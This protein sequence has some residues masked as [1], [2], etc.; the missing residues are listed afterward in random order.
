MNEELVLHILNTACYGLNL[1][2][3]LV[4]QPPYLYIFFDRSPEADL[5]YPTLTET[6]R[7]AAVSAGLPPEYEYLALYSRILGE[8]NPDWETAIYLYQSSI[9]PEASVQEPEAQQEQQDQ[10]QENQDLDIDSEPPI[11]SG[12]SETA[13]T[14]EAFLAESSLAESPSEPEAFA[15]FE[16]LFGVQGDGAANLPSDQ[17]LPDLDDEFTHDPT[18]VFEENFDD[19]AD[20]T[21]LD[22]PADS[23]DLLPLEQPAPQAIDPDQPLDS[24]PLDLQPEEPLLNDRDEPIDEV[25][26]DL[27]LDFSGGLPLPPPPPPPRPLQTAPDRAAAT[28]AKAEMADVATDKAA[29]DKVVTDKAA[30]DET[31]TDKAARAKADEDM[32]QY[33]FRAK[34]KPKASP[35]PPEALTE[36]PASPQTEVSVA[37]SPPAQEPTPTQEPIPESDRQTNPTNPGP[38][39][40]LSSYCFIRNKLMLSSTIKLPAPEVIELIAKL[41]PFTAE[42]KVSIASLLDKLY[43]Q[44]EK[45]NEEGAGEALMYQPADINLEGLAQPVQNFIQE[46][47]ALEP[48][49]FRKSAIWFSRYCYN[50]EKTIAE[51]SIAVS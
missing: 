3:S 36:P 43:R 16:S 18:I 29:T 41:H 31:P 51:L 20:Q 46:I 40:D 22:Q 33:Y 2:F 32:S 50:P 48:E 38:T 1:H 11:S 17:P 25:D 9:S 8:E 39:A 13:E 12:F 30:T 5:N 7:L 24:S 14:P 10:D 23:P 44:P 27:D 19:L 6:I 42:E 37:S 28:S 26:V 4:P 47:L 35:P 15:D 49:S 34:A 45:S 21:D